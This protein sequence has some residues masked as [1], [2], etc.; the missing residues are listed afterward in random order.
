M[1]L[2]RFLFSKQFAKHLLVALILLLVIPGLLYLYLG[3]FTQHGES[4]VVPD[5]RGLRVDEAESVLKEQSLGYLVI[6]SVYAAGGERGTIF[7]QSPPPQSNVKETRDIYLTVYRQTAPSEVLKVEEGMDERVAEIIL[8]NKGITF[9]KRF[10]EHQLLH[11]MVVKVV[12]KGQE[13]RPD[14]KVRKGD[15]VTLVIGQRSDEKTSVPNLIGFPLDT[16]RS[17]LSEARLSLGSTLYDGSVETAN[18][19]M[20]A[21]VYAQSPPFDKKLEVPAGSIVDVFL[22]VDP[23]RI[24]RSSPRAADE[25]TN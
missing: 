13:L 11:G 12:Q 24:N 3:W 19:S 2:L 20:L 23:D 25:T 7:Q 18:D 9:E 4:V 1:G 15:R 5:V 8:E 17:R 14:A 16:V 10:E 21:R 6:D 22:T